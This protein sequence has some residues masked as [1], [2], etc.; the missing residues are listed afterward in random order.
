MF[1]AYRFYVGKQQTAIVQLCLFILGTMTFFIPVLLVALGIW[2]FIDMITILMGNFEN[3]KG[4]KL[5]DW[6]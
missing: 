2:V 4:E 3:S 5:I 1:G 6:T